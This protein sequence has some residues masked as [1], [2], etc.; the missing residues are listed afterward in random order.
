MSRTD[1]PDTKNRRSPFSLNECNS[2][3]RLPADH[4]PDLLWNLGPGG[5]L[6]DVSP[7]WESIAGYAA[8]SLVGTP[9]IDLVH[10]DDIQAFSDFLK[11]VM[12]TGKIL[13]SAEY[14]LRHADGTWHRHA[15]TVVPVRGTGGECVCLVGVSRQIAGDGPE[16]TSRENESKFRKIFQTAPDA[17]SISRLSDGAYALVNEAYTR[18][19]GHTEAELAGKTEPDMNIWMNPAERE[20]LIGMLGS[21]GKIRNFEAEWRAK[22]GTIRSCILYATVIDLDGVPHLLCVTHDATEQKLAERKHRES[23]EKFRILM[24]NAT[25]SIHISQDGMMKFVNSAS[26]EIF[27]YSKASS[28]RSRLSISFIRTTGRLYSKGIWHDRRERFCL[29]DTPTG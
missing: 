22:D 3:C 20:R 18:L 23:E 11:E 29:R 5:L 12:S 24:D 16:K 19:T 28:Y 8:E 21:E 6:L 7:S 26:V 25:E 13:R 10:A 2:G 14:R 4:C 9:F 17:I 27:G 15:A 1:N